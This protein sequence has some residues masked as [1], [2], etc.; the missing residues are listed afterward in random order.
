[1]L[2]D[3]FRVTAREVVM[4]QSEPGARTEGA[5][6]KK[7]DAKYEKP[8]VKRSYSKEELAEEVR[9]HGSVPSPNGGM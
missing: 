2:A 9:P 8:K 7:K 6:P 4:K 3:P 5:L 1:M